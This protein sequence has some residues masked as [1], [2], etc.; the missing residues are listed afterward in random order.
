M[1]ETK[2]FDELFPSLVGC[3]MSSEEIR[4]R[5]EAQGHDTL[6]SFVTNY[7]VDRCCLDKEIVRELLDSGKFGR[8]WYGD[9]S[10]EL[11]KQLKEEL[12]L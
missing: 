5:V 3:W 8:G 2:K 7:A 6:A 10:K 4:L 11:L 9:N 12:G 1:D